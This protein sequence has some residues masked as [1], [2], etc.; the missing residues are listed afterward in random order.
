MNYVA[1]DLNDFL[2]D[3]GFLKSVYDPSAETE[4]FWQE[5]LLKHP[6]KS[7]TVSNARNILLTLSDEM[8]SRTPRQE[9]VD[10]MWQNIQE[11][12]ERKETFIKPLWTRLSMIAAS[13]AVIILIASWWFMP[14]D[15]GSKVTYSQLV[16]SSQNILLE[17]S[18]TTSD[19]ITLTLPD[20]S[21]IV[22][23]PNSSV[24]YPKE[25]N[26]KKERE[27]YLTGEA[28]FQV[29]KNPDRPFLVYANELVTKVLGTSFTIKA[30]EDDQQL[31]VAVKTGKVSVFTRTNLCGE[32]NGEDVKA[33]ETIITP[34]QMVLYS[35]KA[36]KIKKFLV[37]APEIIAST[38]APPPVTDF[39]DASVDQI[40]KNLE[41]SYGIDIIYDEQLFGNCLLTAS[42]T[43][44]SLYDKIDLICKGIEAEFNVV[45]ARIVIS[46]KGCH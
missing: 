1:Y 38:V 30:F 37:D 5:F 13:A 27:V 15:T 2:E 3:P 46:G 14:A 35:R 31:E 7:E 25:F 21:Q 11:N 41:D 23:Q 6:E 32:C 42:F 44:E 20:N 24:S 16:A 17:K 19:P 33:N 40:F 4:T 36:E 9:Q 8:T 26:L 34:N 29:K 12:I 10:S 45:D 22:L 39:Q 18:N 43:Q 28:F